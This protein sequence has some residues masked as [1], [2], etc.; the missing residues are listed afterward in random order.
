MSE[1]E[2]HESVVLIDLKK[3]VNYWQFHI[4]QPN[5]GFED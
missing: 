4:A 2:P 1:L 3:K 5:I